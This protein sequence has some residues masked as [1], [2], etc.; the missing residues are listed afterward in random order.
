V[1]RA[2]LRVSST[3]AARSTYSGMAEAKQESFIRFLKVERGEMA[4]EN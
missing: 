2:A 4:E 3:G 1:V